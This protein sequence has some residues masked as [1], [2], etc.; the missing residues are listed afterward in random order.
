MHPLSNYPGTLICTLTT[1]DMK[2]L[3]R[4]KLV[5]EVLSNHRGI[6]FLSHRDEWQLSSLYYGLL[7]AAW[8]ILSFDV[9]SAMS[10]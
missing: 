7:S 10:G 8:Q 2:P 5:R 9:W 6:F 3:C 4:S 1:G